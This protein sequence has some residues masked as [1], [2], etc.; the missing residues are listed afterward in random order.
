MP[1]DPSTFSQTSALIA[2]ELEAQIL[3]LL[4]RIQVPLTIISIMDDGEK[5][6]EMAVFLR[7]FTRLCPKLSL[8]LLS[9]QEDTAA[10]ELLDASMLPA[11]GFMTENNYC[12]AVFHGVPGG[13]ELTG[14]ISA[15]LTFAGAGKPLDKPTLKDIA[16]IKTPAKLQVCVSLACHHCAQVVMNAQRIAMENENVTAHMIDA[17]LYP[18]LVEKYAISRVPV[19]VCDGEIGAT[20]GMTMAELCTLLRKR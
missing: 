18:A 11:T 17:N 16:R 13:K 4:E 15:L 5:C 9:P 10:D 19:L 7:H 12:R 2:P 20:G 3:P 1:I 6:H 14:F 8:K